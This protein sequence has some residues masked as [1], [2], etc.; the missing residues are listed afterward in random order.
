MTALA[1]DKR[2]VLL[3][4]ATGVFSP[5]L[6]R[7][8][9][10]TSR[11]H[12]RSSQAAIQHRR[13]AALLPKTHPASKSYSS[14]SI[15]QC[16]ELFHWFLT[17]NSRCLPTYNSFY[18]EED[19]MHICKGEDAQ[20]NTSMDDTLVQGSLPGYAISPWR[21]STAHSWFLRRLANPSVLAEHSPPDPPGR[22]ERAWL[23]YRAFQLPI[24]ILCD[25]IDRY[26][27]VVSHLGHAELSYTYPVHFSG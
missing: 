10:T 4:P 1:M 22:R 13:A 6:D 3:S 19:R 11:M 12:R 21:R 8:D 16:L 2:R 27:R 14:T 5:Q 23:I 17:D 20:K 15:N 24:Y 7:V 18:L 9:I 25:M 26:R